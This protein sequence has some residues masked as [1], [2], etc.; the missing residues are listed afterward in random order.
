ML[1]NWKMSIGIAGSE[2]EGTVEIWDQEL[3]GLDE[4]RR[5]EVIDKAIY[6]DALAHVDVWPIEE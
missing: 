3:E 6:E 4:E 2:R 5:K 1:I